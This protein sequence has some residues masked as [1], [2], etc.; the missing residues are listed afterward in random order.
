[1]ASKNIHDPSADKKTIAPH[2][3]LYLLPNAFT[4]GT[5][6]AGFYSIIATIGERYVTAAVAVIIAALLDGLDGRIARATG[7]QSEFGTQYDSMADLISFGAAPALLAYHWSLMHLADYGRIGGK[8]GWLAAFIYCACAAMRLARFNAQLKMV[9]KQN[10]QGLASPAA[11]GLLVSF[12]WFAEEQLWDAAGL[13][14][15]VAVFVVLLGILMFSNL[16]YYSFKTM[17]L[18]EQ[19]PLMWAIILLGVFVLLALD[20]AL[21]LLLIG[22]CYVGSGVVMTWRGRNKRQRRRPPSAGE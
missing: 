16:R 12:I 6:F 21:A 11:A 18:Q 9:D 3:G 22:T 13:G 1:M 10:F 2:R 17:P 7:A 15:L 19:R 5:L 14:W 20:T 8:L 4:T